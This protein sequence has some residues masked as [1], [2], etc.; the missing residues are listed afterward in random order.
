FVAIALGLFAIVLVVGRLYWWTSATWLGWLIVG[1][2]AAG[3]AVAVIELN[4]KDHLLDIRWLTSREIIH[5][6]GALLV[7]RIILSEQ[8]SGAI[9]FLRAMGLQN[10]QL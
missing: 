2:I 6:T 1:A 10:E 9:Y 5:F 7:F 3:M 4:R 8:S